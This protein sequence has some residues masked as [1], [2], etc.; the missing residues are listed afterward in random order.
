MLRYYRNKLRSKINHRG[1]ST[2]TE[3]EPADNYVDEPES[4]IIGRIKTDLDSKTVWIEYR[5][6]LKYEIG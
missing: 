3:P 5:E 6:D 4:K 2:T 1:T